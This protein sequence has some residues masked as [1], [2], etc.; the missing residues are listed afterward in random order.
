MRKLIIGLTGQTGAGKSTAS[1]VMRKH[2]CGIVDADLI[3]REAVMPG[4]ECLAV[5]TNAF[6]CDIINPDGSLNR[7]ALAAKAF[8]S[9]EKT[10]LL[11]SLT[12]PYIIEL[13]K[14]RI[15]KLLDKEYNI[16]VFD[17][18][19][20]FESGGD[21]LCNIIVSVT[22][23]EQCRLSRIMTRDNITFEQANARIKAQLSEQ[24]FIEHSDFILD[25]SGETA[26]LTAQAESLMSKLSSYLN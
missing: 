1:Q 2:G 23:P 21:K 22:A 19:Q 6:G 20:L 11:N 12:H 9:K 25:G 15:D 13:A 14:S 17:A 10:E 26:Y 5:L 24:F 8:S 7:S 3:A 18:P 4:T 16:V